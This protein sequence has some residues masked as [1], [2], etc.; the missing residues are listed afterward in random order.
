MCSVFPIYP[1]VGG[2]PQWLSPVC[3]LVG[4]GTELL[5]NG[6]TLAAG[7]LG[8]C[9]ANNLHWPAVLLSQGTRGSHFHLV[10]VPWFLGWKAGAFC[11]S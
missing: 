7:G 4:D 2:L 5:S 3:S 11:H 10:T 8:S 1:L 9:M 6:L